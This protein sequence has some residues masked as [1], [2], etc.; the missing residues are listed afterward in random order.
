M[1]AQSHDKSEQIIGASLVET[2]DL[3]L[4]F[5][6]EYEV[7]KETKMGQFRNSDL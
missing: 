3:L 4:S 5:L 1:Y 7:D 6:K 2:F